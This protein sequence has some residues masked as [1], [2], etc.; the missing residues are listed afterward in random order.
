Q[1][2]ASRL[3]LS[4]LLLL[5]Y[6]PVPSLL[7]CVLQILDR[8]MPF[9]RR[10][11]LFHHR[12]HIRTSLPASA[13]VDSNHLMLGS[14]LVWHPCNLNRK[15]SHQLCAEHL[16]L[17]LLRYCISMG[18]PQVLQSSQ[19]KPWLDVESMLFHHRVLYSKSGDPLEYDLS[20]LEL[21]N[22]L[23]NSAG[24]TCLLF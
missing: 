10:G 22:D 19:G 23:S 15:D 5:Q 2:F 4:L 1:S 7:A 8:P 21:H 6:V 24:R 13:P 14:F 11:W 3:I 17:Y 12:L 18:V 20:D 16:L 9:V